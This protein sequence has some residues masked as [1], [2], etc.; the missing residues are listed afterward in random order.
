M[1]VAVRNRRL[2]K[3]DLLLIA[4]AARSAGHVA[5]IADELI[6]ELR[7]ARLSAAVAGRFGL[8]DDVRG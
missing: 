1:A 3:L 5:F 2:L 8:L 6:A 4:R 7:R